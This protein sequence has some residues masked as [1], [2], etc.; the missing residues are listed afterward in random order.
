MQNGVAPVAPREELRELVIPAIAPPIIQS[1][2][3]SQVIA[4]TTA[5]RKRALPRVTY[6]SPMGCA[7]VQVVRLGRMR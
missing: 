4:L 3:R 1:C 7:H 6:G 2:H 5:H